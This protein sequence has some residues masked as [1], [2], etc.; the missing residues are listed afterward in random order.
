MTLASPSAGRALIVTGTTGSG[1]TTTS[2]AFVA[3]A[4]DLWLHFGVDLFLGTVVPR[5]FVDGGPRDHEGVH[6]VPDDPADPEGPRHMVLGRHGQ[7]MIRTFHAMAAAAVRGGARMVIDHVTTIDPPLLA[8]CL[9][10]FRGLDTF[11]VALRPPEEIIPQR[12]DHRLESI[13]NSLGREHA[14]R[15]NENTKRISRYMSG[16]IFAHDC[17]DLVVDTGAHA[18]G[19]VV[20]LIAEAMAARRGTAFAELTRRL[21]TGAAPF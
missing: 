17:F 19:E 21:D 15:A 2:K 4:D 10:R 8:D 7:E 20:R 11:F 1:K 6:M 3:Q 16:Q 18:P 5:K 13:I 12:I 9:D 14:T